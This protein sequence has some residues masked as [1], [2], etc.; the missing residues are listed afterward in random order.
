[1]PADVDAVEGH[2]TGTRLGD[3][4]EAQA[5]QAVYGADDASQRTLWLG[6]IKSNIG[7]TQAAAGVAGVIKMTMAMR[8]E[9][10][11]RTLHIKEPSKHVDWSAGPVSLLREERS[12]ERNGKPRRAGVSSFGISGTNAHLILEEAP[13]EASLI[14]STYATVLDEPEGGLE[15][16][17]SPALDALPW[18]LSAKNEH[19]LRDQA[20]RLLAYVERCPDIDVVDVGRSLAGRAQLEQRAVVVGADRDELL[21]GLN[22]LANGQDSPTLVSGRVGGAGRLAL[23][24]TG[25]GSQ[26]VGMGAE[27]SRQ[28]PVFRSAFEEA[29]G[30]FDQHLGCSLAQLVLGD[31]SPRDGAHDNVPGREG[32]SH[33]QER[34]GAPEQHGLLDDTMFAQAGLFSLE[35]ALFR[36]VEAWGIR[37][38]YLVGHS[39]GELVAACVAGVFSLDDA[40]RLVAARGRLMGRLPAGGAM[41]AI[42]ASEQ[43]ARESLDLY[44]GRVALAAINSPSSI[45]LSGEEDAVWDLQ[46][47]WEKRG[48]KVKLLRVSHAFHSHLID[49]MLEEYREVA[50]SVSLSAPTI[51]VFSNVT[52]TALRAEQACSVDYWVRHARETVRFAE[53]VQ[54]LYEQGTRSF[55]ELGPDGTLSSMVRECVA[56]R[57]PADRDEQSLVAV[58]LLRERRSE[59]R[60]TLAGLA[61]AWARGG[62]LDWTGVF[63]GL[64]ARS[65]EL[66]TYAFQRERYWLERV[67]GAT[68][69][70]SLGQSS[71]EHP[72]LGATVELAADRGWVFT[73]C[74]SLDTHPWL[75]D[76][77]V[78]GT[79]LLPGTA[80]LELALRACSQAG[81]EGV[82]ELTLHA[83]LILPEEEALEIQV[84][85]GEIKESGARELS[86][87]SRPVRSDED[88][89]I[90]R[91]WVSH[92]SGTLNA[93]TASEDIG[94]SKPLH[95]AKLSLL[96]DPW[97]P[98]EAEPI[99]I[100][101]LY[102]RLA[103]IGFEYGPAFQGLKAAWR[104]EEQIFAEVALPDEYRAQANSFAIHP[105]LLDSAFHAVLGKDA[106]DGS[107]RIP[108]SFG[109]AQMRTSGASSLRICLSAAAEQGVSLTAA[110][111]TG[112]LVGWIDSVLARPLADEHLSSKRRIS[113]NRL[114][115]LDW[116][117]VP[118]ARG[119][120]RRGR[121]IMLREGASDSSMPN[122]VETAYDHIGSLVEALD[123]GDPVPEVVLVDVS[124]APRESSESTSHADERMDGE[125]S[126][127]D[128]RQA[129]H[130]PGSAHALVNQSLGTLQQWLAEER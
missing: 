39:V 61:Q 120:H 115:G 71:P 113:H 50:E 75:A 20:R 129:Q 31:A 67:V 94:V 8:H 69:L 15:M 112:A 96:G 110:D 111:E 97:P 34:S 25:Q 123:R 28:F 48:R 81:M 21:V 59:V 42:Q 79:I 43:E 24:F 57:T 11:P 109:G 87:N 3:P 102:D 78:T 18:V 88:P 47:L 54:G 64:G 16:A 90:E 49:A 130:L 44:E 22:Q 55:L 70:A 85:V 9:A 29:C 108:F 93:R 53:E 37:P 118:P 30:H 65:V 1:R 89:W 41:L 126:R 35:L 83:P 127:S 36:L 125:R 101:D 72:L 68:D 7:H 106:D 26:R 66:P 84:S 117:K 38:D 122:V 116:V 19:A 128:G 95:S 80:F 12:W 119:G 4:I 60:T 114:F 51:P 13:A 76:H 32:P 98:R 27:L 91:E 14:G 46:K 73:G 10:L 99:E 17:R 104:H 2:G 121:W 107:I 62:Q 100:D 5:L 56:D 92:A 45:V 33:E 103:G 124:A 52:G 6:S 58:P 82:S 86:I 77:V 40:C 23:L 74:I 105:A 63:E